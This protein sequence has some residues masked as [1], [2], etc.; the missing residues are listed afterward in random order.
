M[1]VDQKQN[2]IVKNVEQ[3]RSTLEEANLTIKSSSSSA[4]E[5]DSSESE[6]GNKGL[7][8][9]KILLSFLYEHYMLCVTF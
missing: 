9:Y 2:V 1:S 8:L 3:E 5:G 6:T 4:S 7:S